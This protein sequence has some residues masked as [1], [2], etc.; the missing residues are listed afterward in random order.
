MHTLAEHQSHRERKLLLSVLPLSL[1]TSRCCT[2][3]ENPTLRWVF[4][5]SMR[6]NCTWTVRHRGK[7]KE[8]KKEDKKLSSLCQ[9]CTKTEP[10]TCS[11]AVINCPT[12]FIK[13]ALQSSPWY[14]QH[15][16]QLL[17]HFQYFKYVESNFTITL[18]EDGD[19]ATTTTTS[20]NCAKTSIKRRRF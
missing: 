6:Q 13:S 19:G 17:Y 4:E 18:A 1:C 15:Q 2:A 20:F 14:I 16:D 11:V 5:K 3:A 9:N 10:V 12:T 8:K 7:K